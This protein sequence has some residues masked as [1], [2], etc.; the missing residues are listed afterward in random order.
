MVASLDT[1]DSKSDFELLVI[2]DVLGFPLDYICFCKVKGNIGCFLVFILKAKKSVNVY[3]SLKG[4][5]KPV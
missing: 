3:N 2:W 4:C 5:N 1:S